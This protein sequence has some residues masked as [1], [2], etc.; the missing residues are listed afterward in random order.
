[1]DSDQ[2]EE[3]SETMARIRALGMEHG[4]EQ[5]ESDHVDGE[6]LGDAVSSAGQTES[7]GFGDFHL[8]TTFAD[9][10][11]DVEMEQSATNTV[12]ALS[13]TRLTTEIPPTMFHF[14]LLA[15]RQRSTP[16]ASKMPWEKG[17]FS[18][19]FGSR[20]TPS[21]LKP[22]VFSSSLPAPSL[23]SVAYLQEPVPTP[24]RLQ[25]QP[26][27]SRRPVSRIATSVLKI[28]RAPVPFDIEPLRWRAIIRWR[29]IIEADLNATKVGRQLIEYIMDG[30]AESLIVQTLADTLGSKSTNTLLKRSAALMK[31]MAY[32]RK[33]NGELFLQYVEATVYKY[34]CFL[35]DTRAGAT[36]AKG[37]FLEAMVLAFHMLGVIPQEDEWV[38]GRIKGVADEMLAH[39]RPTQQ[40][41]PLTVEEIMILHAIVAHAHSIVDIVIAGYLLFCVYASSRWSDAQIIRRFINDVDQG[42]GYLELYTNCHKTATNA[43]KKSLLLPLVAT[44]P[45]LGQSMPSWVDSWIEAR[46]SA[47]LEFV[48]HPT[49]PTV[50]SN[51]LFG[52]VPM[53]AAEGSRWINDLLDQYG[54]KACG[55]RRRRSHSLKDT[56]LSAAAKFPLSKDVRRA[57]GHHLAPGDF[58]VATYS[59]DFLFE[60]LLELERMLLAIRNREFFPDDSRAQRRALLEKKQNQDASL[61]KV[62][63]VVHRRSEE[64][65]VKIEVVSD[66]DMER[67]LGEEANP[68]G[69]AVPRPHGEIHQED[70]AADDADDDDAESSSDASASSSEASIPEVEEEEML[71]DTVSPLIAEQIDER[72]PYF[73]D[74]NSGLTPVQ[75]VKSGVLHAREGA[76]LLCGRAFSKVYSRVWSPLKYTWPRC[77]VCVKKSSRLQ[78]TSKKKARMAREEPDEQATL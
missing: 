17:V 23:L 41:D 77:A 51:G 46:K 11:H 69:E 58:S 10:M 4:S 30:R 25:Q 1:M 16:D 65:A 40:A 18:D 49:L 76:T 44:C 31:F 22:Q 28:Q 61:Q 66:F 36:V 24:L 57:L 67:D 54:A 27:S 42:S 78:P 47:G 29:T 5:A 62:P 9:F 60:P 64:S 21:F 45:G 59:R 26:S 71:L 2:Y 55:S 12:S 63:A 72:F 7:D 68:G 43:E 8:R 37:F 33:L 73:G 19:I 56:M 53:T 34:V 48:H 38:S 50:H 39:K 15:A 74:S 3:F 6:G 75:H 35:R 20:G 52:S 14:G 70:R 32:S 13:T